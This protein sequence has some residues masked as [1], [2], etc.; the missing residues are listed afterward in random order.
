MNALRNGLKAKRKEAYEQIPGHFLRHF[1]AIAPVG[2]GVAVAANGVDRA[3]R[4]A[5]LPAAVVSLRGNAIAKTPE[6]NFRID[7]GS[8][9]LRHLKS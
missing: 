9:A 5:D 6:Q 7:S 2:A 1:P 8:P 3:C 4:D